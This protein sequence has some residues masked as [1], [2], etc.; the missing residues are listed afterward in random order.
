MS[1]DVLPSPS[2]LPRFAIPLI[3]RGT[4]SNSAKSYV[5]FILMSDPLLIKIEVVSN[6][7]SSLVAKNN[8]VHLIKCLKKVFYYKS[9]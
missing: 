1:K 6:I 9:F 5:I 3:R 8:N 7:L 4:F 2:I